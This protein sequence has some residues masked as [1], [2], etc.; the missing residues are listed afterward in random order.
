[1]DSSRTP[2]PVRPA[3][4]YLSDPGFSGHA[5]AGRRLMIGLQRIG[6]AV[7][8][9]PLQWCSR[10]PLFPSC[11]T[12]E[13]RPTIPHPRGS[14]TEVMIVH[15]TPEF[16]PALEHLVPP[17]VPLVLHTAW[18]FEQLPRDWPGL[19][20]RAEAVIVPTRWN[21]DAFAAAGVRIPIL[22]VPHAHAQGIESAQTEWLDGLCPPDQLMLHSIAGWHPRKRPDVTLEAYARA[23]G[24]RDSTTMILRTTEEV[25]Q[26]PGMP[27]PTRRS[28]RTSWLIADLMHRH[29]PAPRLNVITEV[30]SFEQIA[31]MHRR[32]GCWVS[33]P[34]AEGWD[35]G[36]FDAAVAGCPVV[37]TA[38]GA[39]LEYLDPDSSYLVPGRLVDSDYHRGGKWAV[40]DLDT[41]IDLLRV[42][43]ADP[44]AAAA[45][46]ADQAVRL[47]A[48]Y[49]ASRVATGLVDQLHARGL[50]DA[51]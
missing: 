9:T 3:V 2:R 29:A 10:H 36:C 17:G 20:N 50:V 43:H 45:R 15:A 23:F 40:P 46:A 49:E 39:P 41:A 38:H 26:A 35:M 7:A 31:G 37:T 48:K 30:L 22:V 34:H 4:H 12:A 14:T 27:W 47:Q 8:H 16:L 33:L 21:A 51:R 1:M 24:P 25:E 28:S 11:R 42:I 6:C 19:I 18:E 5:V 44:E 32:S 13:A